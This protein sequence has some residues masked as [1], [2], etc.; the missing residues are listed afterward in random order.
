MLAAVHL[1]EESYYSDL[2]H[3]YSILIMI[4]DIGKA[5]RWGF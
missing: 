1:F 4:D 3:H 2:L 5:V